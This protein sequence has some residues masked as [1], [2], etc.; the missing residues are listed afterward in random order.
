MKRFSTF[1]FATLL[2]AI[3][4]PDASAAET[5]IYDLR[6]RDNFVFENQI[7]VYKD[8]DANIW[9]WGS[10]KE[11][12]E[13]YSGP[14]MFN[15][16][17]YSTDGYYDHV[18]FTPDLSLEP[19]K[20]KVYLQPRKKNNQTAQAANLK[21]LLAQGKVNEKDVDDNNYPVLATYNAL[22]YAAVSSATAMAE[23]PKQVCE[24]D[25]TV[26][27]AYKICFYGKGAGLTLHQT[28]IVKADG[29]STP[30][31]GPGTTD[32]EP[33][34][35]P[36]VPEMVTG[37]SASVEGADVTVTFSLPFSGT[38]G[39]S[40]DGKELK[41]TIY[42]DGTLIAAKGRQMAGDQ[43]SYVDQEVPSG[44]YTYGVDV[45][46]DDLTG[47]RAVVQ[48]EVAKPAARPSESISLP[49]DDSFG[50]G[51]FGTNWY[52]EEVN[53]VGTWE[54]TGKL[55][56]Q[57]PITD[58]YDGDGGMVTYRGWN[59][60]AGEYARLS[61][62]PITKASSPAPVIDFWFRHSS[63]ERCQTHLKVQVS[64]DGGEWKD[65]EG[66][67]VN[68][69]IDEFY[70]GDWKY[71]KYSLS[72]YIEN[73]N[74]YRVGLYAYCIDVN[75]CNLPVDVIKIYNAS[76]KEVVIDSCN[77]PVE[78][79]AGSDV[80]LAITLENRGSET[81]APSAYTV[82]VET[83]FPTEIKFEQKELRQFEATVLTAKVPVTAE[84]VLDGPEY[85]FAISV[86]VPGNTGDAILKSETYKVKTSF[87]DHKSPENLKPV[88]SGDKL[89]GLAWES[90]KDLERQNISISENFND[91]PAHHQETREVDGK[92]ESY[93]VEGQKGNFNGFVSL[94]FDYA[95]G[96]TY[97]S[98]NGSEFQV[99]KD[100]TSGSIPQGHSGQYI[101]LT[102]PGNTQQD[103]W[104]ITPVLKAG[105][106]S[107]INCQIRIAYIAREG[108]NANNSLEVLY[109]TDEEYDARNPESSFTR[110][111]YTN[112][113]KARTGDLPH[114]GL[115]HWLFL[116]GIPGEAK[117]VAFHFN[118]KSPYQTGV[119]VDR[120]N[121]SETD[122]SPLEGYY[123]YRRN[124]GRLN[125][126]PLA[127]TELTYALSG[128][129]LD[130]D[131]PYYVTALYADG[132]SNPGN[133]LGAGSGVESVEAP[134]VTQIRA[135]NGGVM[136]TGITG[137]NAEVYTMD[138]RVAARVKTAGLTV[139]NLEPGLYAVK[140]GAATAKILVK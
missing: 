66:S 43:I 38:N 19:G 62:A 88:Y 132:E 32:P 123:V 110:S 15:S 100:F 97:Y 65:I 111:F 49:I 25:I 9:Q 73:C 99:F 109:T 17:E 116:N 101:A 75:N 113:S 30:D 45:T 138:G 91:L 23:L 94:D 118:T 131:N 95:D 82:S 140:A 31:P 18:Y 126:E 89:M 103:D 80:E 120:I 47:Q 125:A 56:N 102:L 128:A 137:E 58:V 2:A 115:Y 16:N 112:V 106:T 81:I 24:F 4:L 28:Y 34:P 86:S 96:G 107:V 92:S 53:G 133:M 57:L 54:V 139:I 55:T 87:V 78:V 135:I 11:T 77:I 70:L 20:Y 105:E 127:A 39:E 1:I 93:W 85:E 124:S 12:G 129:S 21:I 117:Y 51:D 29:S 46:L 121:I 72:P 8:D 83:D 79:K 3:L 63:A 36:I 42:R 61:T 10:Y 35:D 104:L 98:V 68:T 130:S 119:W 7:N 50:D 26:A 90:V 44:T 122:L 71:Y 74:T 76:N 6:E 13:D 27:G 69:Y 48:V 108:D 114:D 67:D 22:P 64:C 134:G 84:E 40:L 41:Y 136:I 37:L 5:I 14:E 52:V 33:E 59:S 60:K